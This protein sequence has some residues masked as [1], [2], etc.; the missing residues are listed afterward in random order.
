MRSE[1]VKAD[2]VTYQQALEALANEGLWEE[3]TALYLKGRDGGLSMT[4]R[5]YD[6]VAGV[7]EANGRGHESSEMGARKLDVERKGKAKGGEDKRNR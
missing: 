3:A 5:S 4:Q 1:A 2:E 6:M 7:R